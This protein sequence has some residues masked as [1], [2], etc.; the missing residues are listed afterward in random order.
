MSYPYIYIY[1][2]IGYIWYDLRVLYDSKYVYYFACVNNF[3]L[4]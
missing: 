2:Y 3:N 4:P 1:I